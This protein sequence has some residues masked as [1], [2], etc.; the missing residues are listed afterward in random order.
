MTTFRGVT[1]LVAVFV[2]A[3]CGS[4]SGRQGT[5]IDVTGAGPTSTVLAGQDAVWTMT[6]TN[7]GP[8]D[9]SNVKIVDNIGNQLA[10]MS[11]TCTSTGGATCPNPVQVENIIPTLPNGG[12]LIFAVTT[13]LDAGATGTVANT[14]AAT[15]AEEIDST[16]DSATVT[17]TASSIVTNIVVAG[18]GPTTTTTGGG[19]VDFIMTVTNNG[20]DTATDFNVYDNVGSGLTLTGITCSASGGAVCPSTVGVVTAIPSLVSGGTLT[21][22]VSTV[23]NQQANGTVDNELSVNVTTNPTKSDDSFFATAAVVSSDLTIVG[24]A[25]AGPLA[26]GAA[27]AFTMVVTNTGPGIASNVALVNVLS[28]GL[29]ASAA[30][31]C[32]A[33]GGAVC[34]TPLGQSMTVPTMP[35]NGVLTFT[36]PFTVNAGTNGTVTDSLTATSATYPKGSVTAVAGV[37]SSSPDVGVTETGNPFVQGG[38][39]AVFTA[40]VTNDSGVTA[41]NATV[42]YSLSGSAGSVATVTCQPSTGAICPTTLGPSMTVPTLEAGRFLTFTF[43]VPAPTPAVGQVLSPIVNAVTVGIAGDTNSAN[44]MA[45]FSTT[46]IASADGSYQ[47]YAANGQLY[48]MVMNMETLSYTIAVPGQVPFIQESFVADASGGGYTVGGAQHFRVGPDII[49]GGQIFAA[50]G[51]VIPYL[52]AKAFGTTLS[53]L[54]GV[55]GGLYDLGTINYPTGGGSATTQAGTAKVSGNVLTICETKLV[56]QQQVFLTQA[57]PASANAEHNYELSV[58]GTTYTATDILNNA[59]TFNFQLAIIGNTVTL[60]SAGPAPGGS[61]L[62]TLFGVPD[63]STFAGEFFYG[64]STAFGSTPSDWI[65]M[66]LLESNYSYTGQLGTSGDYPLTNVIAGSGPYSLRVGPTAAAPQIYVMQTYPLTIE[67]GAFGGPESGMMQVTFTGPL[68]PSP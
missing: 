53:Q 50:G 18:K 49:V 44:N 43:S 26:G 14:M 22:N 24:T 31:T 55:F 25:P 57:C 45:T 34:P 60:V 47:L 41:S 23:A 64:A 67:F 2:L 62:Q 61:S 6:V 40:I 20:P 1:I 59:E 29:T 58:S 51:P 66:T 37:G 30:V 56:N 33:A 27:A 36:F 65:T 39:N 63:S 38:S 19:P 28:A 13:K 52:A 3:A 48:T 12:A 21:F 7:A 54:G 15:F 8:Y 35:V 9:A 10:L 68:P 32:T 46:P 17:A 11:I 16:E 5:Q 4:P 42:S